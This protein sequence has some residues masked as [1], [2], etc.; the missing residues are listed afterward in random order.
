MNQKYSMSVHRH[1]KKF[2]YFVNSIGLTQNILKAQEEKCGL[3]A[4]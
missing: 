1:H 4:N 2:K 3:F